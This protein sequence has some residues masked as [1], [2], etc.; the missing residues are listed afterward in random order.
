MSL[1]PITA[2]VHAPKKYAD[3][4]AEFVASLGAEQ[5]LLNQVRHSFE[6]EPV[7]KTI[8][9][10]RLRLLQAIKTDHEQRAAMI[11]QLIATELQSL[12]FKKEAYEKQVDRPG[13]ADRVSA[14]AK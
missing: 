6:G 5:A 14:V 8:S 1:R 4:Y 12:E 13:H 7:G 9:A 10:K 11:D 3:L 2:N